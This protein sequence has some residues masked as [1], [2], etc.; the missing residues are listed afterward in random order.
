MNKMTV[1]ELESNLQ[2]QASEIL[3]ID[4]VQ[5]AMKGNKYSQRFLTR[6]WKERWSS[7]KKKLETEGSVYYVWWMDGVNNFARKKKYWKTSR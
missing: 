2:K 3:D 1:W 5:P 6:L 7:I 4:Y